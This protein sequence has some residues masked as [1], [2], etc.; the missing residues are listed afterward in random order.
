MP[1]GPSSSASCLVSIA[2]PGRNPLETAIPG[3]GDRT[4]EDSTS[5]SDPPSPSTDDT[6]RAIRTAPRNTAANDVVHWSSVIALHRARPE[7][8]RR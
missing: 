8:R 7:G 1:R 6:S 4:L 2:K 5:A 3:S